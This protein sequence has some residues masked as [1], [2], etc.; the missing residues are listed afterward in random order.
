M[1]FY[2]PWSRFTKNWIFYQQM[3]TL[4]SDHDYELHLGGTVKPGIQKDFAGGVLN[5]GQG[6]GRKLVRRQSEPAPLTLSFL[7]TVF[8]VACFRACCQ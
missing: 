4:I 5:E 1:R 6:P 7:A 3:K 8:R 2:A